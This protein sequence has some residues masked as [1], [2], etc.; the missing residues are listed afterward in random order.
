MKKESSCIAVF[1]IYEEAMA[2]IQALRA[3]EV[4]KSAYEDELITTFL[5]KEI[6]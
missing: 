3:K 6:G 4:N 2:A 5:I 1:T